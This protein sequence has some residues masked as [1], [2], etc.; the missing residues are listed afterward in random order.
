VPEA[1]EASARRG[2]HIQ[3]T[4]LNASPEKMREQVAAFMRGK[5]SLGEVGRD[6][7]L[8]LMRVCCVARDDADARRK[9]ELAH[10]YYGRFHNVFTGPGLVDHGAIRPL[11]LN[12][13]LEELRQ[14]ILICT[15][16]EMVERLKAYEALGVD[17][18]IM[19]IHIGTSH[20]ENLEMLQRFAEEVMPAFRPAT[21]A[22][23][24][25]GAA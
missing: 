18:F 1:I 19:N 12:Q 13:S 14:G 6:L 23:R 10:D 16:G 24:A 7:R 22:P 4:P 5:Q 8:G 17:D 25:A 2:F 3:T 20:T 9:L 15:A 11:P 21:G